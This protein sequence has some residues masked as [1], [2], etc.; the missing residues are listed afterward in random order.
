MDLQRVATFM[1]E[2]YLT[3][4]QVQRISLA[5]FFFFFFF[6]FKGSAG[7]LVWEP[8]VCLGERRE[9]TRDTPKSVTCCKIHLNVFSIL[10]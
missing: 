3:S 4:L 8:S 7:C 1:Q 5:G 6:L 10:K 9:K 2:P